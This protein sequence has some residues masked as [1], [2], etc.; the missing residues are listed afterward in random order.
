[1]RD[2]FDATMMD[3]EFLTEAEQQKLVINPVITVVPKSMLQRDSEGRRLKMLLVDVTSCRSA[4]R[5]WC[6]IS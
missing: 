6:L 1:M 3:P 2:G 4:I 5:A